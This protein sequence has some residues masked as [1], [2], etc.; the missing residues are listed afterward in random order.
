MALFAA[1]LMNFV[2]IPADFLFNRVLK[3]QNGSYGLG[4]PI[5]NPSSDDLTISHGG[6]NGRPQAFLVI[7]PRKKTAVAILATAKDPRSFEL[8]QLGEALLSFLDQVAEDKS[9]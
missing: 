7:K 9:Q 8:D 4:W 6:S 2:Y 3:C 1:G 5:K